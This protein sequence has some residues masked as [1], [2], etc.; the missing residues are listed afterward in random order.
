M[1]SG[2][3]IFVGTT[4]FTHHCSERVSF[5]SSPAVVV[6][7]DDNAV[8]FSLL[9]SYFSLAYDVWQSTSKGT[10]SASKFIACCQLVGL[11]IHRCFVDITG[12]S[13]R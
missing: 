2:L 4:L 10:A 11:D 13:E 9:F 3:V 7:G 8:I 1:S 12:D 5:S 6:T